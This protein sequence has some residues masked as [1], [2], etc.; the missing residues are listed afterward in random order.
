MIDN[1]TMMHLLCQMA[2]LLVMQS[3]RIQQSSKPYSFEVH[4][5]YLEQLM[6]TQLSGSLFKEW[7]DMY[8]PWADKAV[9]TRLGG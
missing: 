7:T 6:V 3:R 9:E 2:A 1:K 4:T 8:I 5:Q